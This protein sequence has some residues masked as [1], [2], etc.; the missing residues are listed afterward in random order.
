MPFE[1]C[2][3]VEE[4]PG[5]SDDILIQ[6]DKNPNTQGATLLGLAGPDAL[7]VEKL[8]DEAAS[9]GIDVLWVF[10]HDLVA[11][12]GEAKIKK[13]AKKIKLF[14]MLNKEITWDIDLSSMPCGL[15]GTIYCSEMD[16]TGDMGGGNKAGAACGT[17]YC[18]GQ[19]ARD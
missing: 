12:F 5:F 10:G 17:G 15:N 1:Q 19:C 7:D 6:A 14:E 16:K 4:E 9:G 8:V 3:A 11:L 18:D 2:D 13:I